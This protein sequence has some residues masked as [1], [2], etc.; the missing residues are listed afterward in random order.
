MNVPVL[1][2]GETMITSGISANHTDHLAGIHTICPQLSS[3]LYFTGT[4][5][6]DVFPTCSSLT[7]ELLGLIPNWRDHHMVTS[8]ERATEAGYQ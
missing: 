7:N 3:C 4:V 6:T 1:D 8:A 5:Y 2:H